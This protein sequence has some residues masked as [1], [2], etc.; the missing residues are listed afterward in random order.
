MCVQSLPF[1]VHE[2]RVH[3]PSKKSVPTVT[4]VLLFSVHT[5]RSGRI[6]I[7]STAPNNRSGPRPN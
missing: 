7:E 4:S 2:Q 5:V 6:S 1:C 3:G